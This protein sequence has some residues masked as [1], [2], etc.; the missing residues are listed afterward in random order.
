MIKTQKYYDFMDL[1]EQD[2][3]PICLMRQK[4]AD[5]FID[6]FLYEGVNDRNFR[7]IIRDNGGMCRKHAYD[8]M[9]Q[10]DPLAHSILYSDLIGTYLKNIDA[11]NKPG[12]L[13]CSKEVEADEVTYRAFMEYFSCDEAFYNK[14]ADT[15]SCICRPH[16]KELKIRFKKNKTLLDGLYEVQIKNLEVAKEHLDEIVRKHDYRYAGEAL[17]DE[18][19]LAWQRAV[20]L[21]VGR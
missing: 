12:C 15:K 8:M 18:E 2:D 20:K 13:V 14:F 9:A 1:F 4:W 5:E 6:A 19:K 21:M 10:G 11:K 17:T 3:C 7:K 16:L